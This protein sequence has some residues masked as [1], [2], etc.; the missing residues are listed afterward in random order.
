MQ[1]TKIALLGPRYDC[2]R[3]WGSNSGAQGEG[4]EYFLI[5]FTP[6]FTLARSASAF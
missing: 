4:V 1:K 2:I 3:W 6:R 5:A